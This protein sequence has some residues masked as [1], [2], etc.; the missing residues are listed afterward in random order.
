MPEGPSVKALADKLRVY[1]GAKVSAIEAVDGGMYSAKG[2]NHASAAMRKKAEDFRADAARVREKILAGRA[3]RITKIGV[4][5]KVLWIETDGDPRVIRIKLNLDGKLTCSAAEKNRH[6]RFVLDNPD[7]GLHE[8]VW[9]A[10]SSHRGRINLDAGPE[11]LD[12][13]LRQLGPDPLEPTGA[14]DGAGADFGL[15]LPAPDADWGALAPLRQSRL[16]VPVALMDQR[17]V[18]GVGNYLRAEIIYRAQFPKKVWDQPVADLTDAEFREL[19]RATNA[20]TSE[21]YVGKL[22]RRTP[23][24][25][26]Y[27]H[28]RAEHVLMPSGR[29]FYYRR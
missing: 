22:A 3:P 18:A 1:V 13:E 6:V 23:R 29:K 4:K 12:L 24:R 16:K 14:G 27:Q 19:I 20:I 21:A 17:L 25:L 26:A 15:P 7:V 9:F 2:L 11:C 5:G 28:P 10:D 8:T